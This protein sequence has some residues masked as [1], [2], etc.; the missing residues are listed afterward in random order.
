MRP[1]S[2]TGINKFLSLPNR[3]AFDIIRSRHSKSVYQIFGIQRSGNHAII[4]WLID[5]MSGSVLHCN[6]VRKNQ[7]PRDCKKNFRWG[8]GNSH[9]IAS[10]EEYSPND[11]ELKFDSD[12]YGQFTSGF[13]LL[14]LRDPFN[15]F[16]SRYAWEKPPGDRF[17]EKIKTRERKISLWKEYANTYLKWQSHQQPQNITINYNQWCVDD[18]YRLK[19]AKKLGFE[20]EEIQSKRIP[21]NGGGSSFTGSQKI[22]DKNIFLQRFREF[23]NDEKFKSI[24]KD[25]ELIDLSKKIFGKIDGTYKLFR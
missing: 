12:L 24:F 3:L 11:F 9:L 6:H 13:N 22:V 1:Q 10:F 21:K 19:L 20:I 7:H 5:N 25:E 15:L 23:E 8:L 17:R 18:E 2:Y 16:A 14:L 4:N